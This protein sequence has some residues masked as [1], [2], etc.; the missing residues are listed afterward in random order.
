[1]VLNLELETL[2]NKIHHQDT[3]L[4]FKLLG[5]ADNKLFTRADTVDQGQFGQGI[6]KARTKTWLID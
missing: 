5:Q 3:G 6:K 2:E 4:M 1:M